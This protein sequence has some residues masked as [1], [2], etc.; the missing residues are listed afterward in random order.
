MTFRPRRAA[1][2]TQERLAEA[3][4]VCA[5]AAGS[6][7]EPR[8][9]EGIAADQW[10]RAPLLGPAADVLRA[11]GRWSLDGSPRRFD[12]EDWWYRTEFTAPALEAG[13]EFWLGFDGLATVADVWLN[14]QPVLH[15]SSMFVA[16]ECNVGA[17]LKA[18]PNKLVLRFHALDTL[19]AA[20]RPRP[21]WRA[22]M[23]AHQQLRWL[24]TTL[25]GR[26]PG[27]S[28]PAAVVGP[29]RDI[30]CE[31][32]RGLRVVSSSVHAAVSPDGAGTLGASCVLH[33]GPGQ[34][35]DQVLLEAER[36]GVVQRA[37]LQPDATGAFAGAVRIES[38]ALWWPHT[39][40]EPALY[41]VRLVI[42]LRDVPEPVVAGL[43]STGFRSLQLDTTEGQFKLHVNGV[44]VFCRGACWTP[45]DVVSLRA[46]PEATREAVA[47]VRDA[48]MN[49]LRV[50][51]TMVYEDA[52]FFD[53]C[54]E[55]GVL[56]WQ[57]FMFANMDYP[58][59]DAAFMADVNAEVDQQ[60]TC[61]QGRPSLAV[62]CGNSEVEQQAA[63]WGAPR[64]LWSPP[65]F[66]ASLR[67][68]VREALPGVPYWPSSAH[69][70]AFPHQGNA[71][72]TSYYGVGAYLRAPEDA[73]RCELSFATECL[74]FANVPDER[75]LSR[76][77]GGLAL[78][79]HHPAW[80]ERTPRDL[81]AGWDFEDVRDHYLALLFRV[82]PVACRSLDHERYLALSRIVTGEMMAGA[83]AE[84]RRPGSGCGGALV[85]FLRDLWAGAGWGLVDDAGLPKAC[86]H[87]LRRA[88]QPVAV[89]ITDE[90]GNGL[91][92]HVLN[93]PARPL[94]AMLEIAL[95]GPRDARVGHARHTI[96]LPARGSVSLPLAAGL[97]GFTD[98]SY[99]YR[100]GPPGVTLVH[101]T[102]SA[103]DGS[104]LGEAF[105]FPAGRS[106]LTQAD[107]GLAARLDAQRAELV[108]STVGLAQHV[109]IDLDG[110]VPADN[111]FHLPP[112][113][114][115]RVAV[116]RI[117][118]AVATPAKGFVW[119]LNSDRPVPI[120]IAA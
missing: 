19:L 5:T 112:G 9:I 80:K 69:G 99:A 55:L 64:E 14:G 66:H 28:P 54:D 18:G 111:D 16:H 4:E 65:L 27:W 59:H 94:S 84:W 60:L 30:W 61:W 87:A 38:A 25:L 56:V 103:A 7:T 117:G 101:A 52:A 43:G 20:K 62:V 107:L 57:E 49:M 74:A 85:W 119:A 36:D 3:W 12:A 93:E 44:P 47:Q 46:S 97:E 120:L 95:Y 86:F 35:L 75:T 104:A 26:T 102:L 41:Q 40:G 105:H 100:F 91:Y 1:P 11:T 114:Q 83:F 23:V 108:L 73:R 77:P 81:N 6:F 89:S 98:L 8:Q 17:L 90:G 115:R 42:Q 32:R 34:T 10:V 78:R 29:W 24:R 106:T 31:R 96:D 33:T 45:L 13:D 109:H 37:V 21:R 22:P 72:T 68:R 67:E 39:H 58:E 48:G 116:R 79:V 70:G 53:A 51:G 76:M 50:G 88:L 82:D 63:M 2:C 118:A 113:A 92:A 110:H 71:G 15:S